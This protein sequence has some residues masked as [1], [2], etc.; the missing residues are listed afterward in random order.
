MS[1]ELTEQWRN[2][3]LKEGLYYIEGKGNYHIALI[4]NR[5]CPVLTSPYCEDNVF[6]SEFVPVAPVPTYEEWVK[7][8]TWYTEKS[9][10]ELLEK[11]DE[12]E[13]RLKDAEE[14]IKYAVSDEPRQHVFDSE[15]VVDSIINKCNLYLKKNE[16]KQNEKN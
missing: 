15:D 2:G 13:S 12:L 16:R 1:K 6:E 8:G 4:R 7:N 5:Y 3:T 10:T 11:I 9:H 14:V